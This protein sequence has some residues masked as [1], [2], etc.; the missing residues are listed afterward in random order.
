MPEITSSSNNPPPFFTALLFSVASATYRRPA[1]LDELLSTQKHWVSSYRASLS[2]PDAKYMLAP[3]TSFFAW[4][5]HRPFLL[6]GI[7]VLGT[8]YAVQ[9]LCFSSNE[10]ED[11]QLN[12]SSDE[13]TGVLK[14]GFNIGQGLLLKSIF[15][16]FSSWIAESIFDSEQA[17]APLTGLAYDDA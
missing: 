4:R 16:V 8:S 14:T 17:S 3:T 12:A 11:S 2:G 13:N 6:A 5:K 9:L 10:S 1:S 7:A 15:H